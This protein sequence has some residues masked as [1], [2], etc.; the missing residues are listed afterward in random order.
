M[1][2]LDTATSFFKPKVLREGQQLPNRVVGGTLEWSAEQL[3]GYAALIGHTD[4]QTLPPLWPQVRASGL[5][6]QLFSARDFPLSPI[7]MVH[8]SNVSRH[9]KPM[10]A[11]AKLRAEA[12][13]VLQGPAMGGVVFELVTRVMP[14]E[15]SDL[16]AEYRAS[17]LVRAP[18]AKSN[19][20]RGPKKEEPADTRDWRLL[21]T[22]DVPSNQGRRYARVSGDY[23]PIHLTALTAKPL[24]F[25]RAIAHGMWTLSRL[26]SEAPSSKPQIIE[27]KFKKPLFLPQ[28]VSLESMADGDSRSLRLR[29]AKQVLVEVAFNNL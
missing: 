20:P 8:V 10:A 27:A 3:Q 15:S 18:R 21:K 6:L 26:V 13:C 7:G 11:D 19:E 12:E 28:Q 25:K 14:M 1:G 17:I 9:F 16:L 2:L 23:N 5:H 29:D 22:L 4:A 24:G